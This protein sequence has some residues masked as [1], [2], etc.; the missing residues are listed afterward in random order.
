MIHMSADSRIQWLHQ[1]IL[2][3]SYPNA[4]LVADR[5]GISHRQAQRD[6]DYLKNVLGA[7]IDYNFA[8]RG[9]F[10]TEPFEL[11]AMEADANDESMFG[12]SSLALP[13]HAADETAVQLQIPYSAV[14]RCRD[15][16][17]LVEFRRMIVSD[18]GK[19]RYRCEFHSVEVFLSLILSADADITVLSPDWLRSRLIQSAQRILKNNPP[20]EEEL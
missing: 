15:K 20:E 2:S 10:Y 12:L 19:H 3:R 6:V 8:K 17:A 18:E 5:F 11:P 7:P 13:G 4:R 16:L 1:K 14:I 9:F